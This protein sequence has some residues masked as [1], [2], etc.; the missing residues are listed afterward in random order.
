MPGPKQE[1]DVIVVGGGINGLTTAAYLQKAGM[2]VAVFEKRD[3]S[4]TFCSTEEVM[5]P[6]VKVNMHA[7]LL[8]AHFGPAYV[9]LELERFGLELLRPPGA[10]YAYFYPFL[11]GNALLFSGRDARE[12]YEAWA[13]ISPKDAET[14]R[15]IVNYFGPMTPAIAHAGLVNK[16]TDE[17]F[18]ELL[19][20]N[21]NV[22]VMPKD[23][24][25]MTGVELIE[26]L[27][28]NEQIKVGMLSYPATSGLD[29]ISSRFTGPLAVLHFLTMFTV[30]GGYTARGGSHDLVHSLVRCFV[31][32]GGKIYYNCPVER[33]LIESGEAKGIALSKLASY[34]EAVFKASKAVISD[35]SAKPTFLSLIGKEHLPA[36]AQAALARFDYRGSTL[37]TNYYVMSERPNFAA[38]AKFPEVNNT[39]VFNCGAET[40]RD[41]TRLI[42]ACLVRDVLPDPPVV[43]GAAFNYCI[44]DPTQAPPGQYTILTWAMVPYDLRPLGGPEKWDD[45]REDYGD[46]VEDV[47]VQYLPNLKTSKIAR[48]VNTPHDYMRRNPHCGGNMHPS[49]AVTEGQMWSWKPFS[50]CNAPSTPIDRFFIC[51]SMGV[52]N[53][54]NL[55][56]GY[57]AAGEVMSVL[58]IEKPEW[59]K[60]QC[61]DGAA[62]LIRREGAVQRFTVD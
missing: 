28:E 47:L 38:A 4:G 16:Q 50:G 20:A 30:D 57:V 22:P 45:I 44:A 34:P 51:Q 48:Y 35:L 13:R 60:A 27:F 53:Y 31:H 26:C 24:L 62:E 8:L 36:S 42:D 58:G 10:K 9:D 17:S 23:W 40:M 11:D 25:Y 21:A 15:S 29:V 32:H 52:S 33:V 46:K 43:W 37:F 55:G 3:E 7:S 61:F 59:W 54:T 5:H 41:V 2:S 14:Y 19:E 12:T 1:Y 18:L 39:F 49:G 56:A 6:G